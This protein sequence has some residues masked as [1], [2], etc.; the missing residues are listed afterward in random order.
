MNPCFYASFANVF[1]REPNRFRVAVEAVC[2]KG[3]IS[4][5]GGN[6]FC[7][8]IC[9]DRCRNTIPA[10]RCKV[11]MQARGN[12]HRFKSCLN[13]QCTAATER[14]TDNT[15]LL[16]PC[17]V[18]NASGKGFLDGGSVGIFPITSLMQSNTGAV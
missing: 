17:Q 4:P 8:G 7:T 1:F 12:V 13:Q 6:C 16:D 10:F 2:F 14:V 11:A 5:N 18:N 3:G 15:I 9:P